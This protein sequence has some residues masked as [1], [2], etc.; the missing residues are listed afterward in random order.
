MKSRLGFRE[1]WRRGR[2]KKSRTKTAGDLSEGDGDSKESRT[3]SAEVNFGS[4]C[5][6]S[7]SDVAIGCK[8]KK[9]EIEM[10]CNAVYFLAI[11]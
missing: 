4:V 2:Q 11:K 5:G 8:R 7:V 9:R 10:Y 6:S 3:S 1:G